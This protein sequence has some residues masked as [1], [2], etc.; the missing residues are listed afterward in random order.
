MDINY[1]QILGIK[2][3]IQLIF[4]VMIQLMA[5]TSATSPSSCM[6][7]FCFSHLSQQ[8]N[9]PSSCI[10]MLLLFSSIT[11]VA[12]IVST[13]VTYIVLNIS[14]PWSYLFSTSYYTIACHLA[15][16]NRDL[17]ACVMRLA[18]I[19]DH[20]MSHVRCLI[21]SHVRCHLF[22][23]SAAPCLDFPQCDLCL[24]V[25]FLV[26]NIA[27]AQS[28]TVAKCYIMLSLQTIP[29]VSNPLLAHILFVTQLICAKLSSQP[30]AYTC[31]IMAHAYQHY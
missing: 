16:H 25:M 12:L 13:L 1:N 7:C 5:S 2:P 21:T 18:S 14:H 17:L 11:I 26:S 27:I 9:C 3:L 30:M 28:F 22:N 8:L 4:Q 23:A 15:H 24:H 31:C 19:L 29:C 10:P 20:Y 6:P